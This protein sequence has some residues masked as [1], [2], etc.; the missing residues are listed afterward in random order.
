MDMPDGIARLAPCAHVYLCDVWGRPTR[1]RF[2]KFLLIKLI[3]ID[4]NF[5][6]NEFVR[7]RGNTWT[8]CE[9]HDSNG[10]GLGDMWWTDKFTYFRIIHDRGIIA[11][12]SI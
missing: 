6:G 5:L 1:R 11:S 2:A 3:T 8:M 9:F 4:S 7:C 10:N 12:S